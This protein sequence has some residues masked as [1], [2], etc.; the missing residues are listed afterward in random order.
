MQEGSEKKY[1][2]PEEQ[3]KA[4]ENQVEFELSPEEESQIMKK[5]QDINTPGMAVH[6]ILP[7]LDSRHFGRDNLKSRMIALDKILRAGLLGEN[8][9]NASHTKNEEEWKIDVRKRKPVAVFF[10]II[11]RDISTIDQRGTWMNRF[12]DLYDTKNPLGI[13]FDLK[14]FKED[15]SSDYLSSNRLQRGYKYKNRHFGAHGRY[16]S[17]TYD[18]AYGFA[19]TFRVPPRMFKGVVFRLDENS[20]KGPGLESNLDRAKEIAQLMLTSSNDRATLLPVYDIKGNLWW[21]RQLTYE[22]VKKL[23]AEKN[24]GQ[25]DSSAAPQ[26]DKE[27]E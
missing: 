23:V 14:T 2:P 3:S 10:N 18:P 24:T 8:I 5:V 4:P 19:L 12:D 11:G 6:A 15:S 22:E 21:P 16:G 13:I 7:L 9:L 17:H 27:A 1:I 26:N 20:N 25:T